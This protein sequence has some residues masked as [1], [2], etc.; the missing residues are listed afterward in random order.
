ME[1][2]ES[3]KLGPY[4]LLRR[5]ARGGMS[6]VYLV[7]DERNKQIYALKMVRQQDEEDCLRFQREIQVLMRL[8]HPHILPILDIGSQDDICYYVMPYIAQGTLKKRLEER[9]P[10]SEKEAETILTSIA[11]A[12]HFL[13]EA[14]FVHR[15]VKPSN[16]LQDSTDHVWLAD[17]GLVRAIEGESDLTRTGC[18]VGTPS[19]M[20]PEL[21]TE[22]ANVSSDI[23]ALGIVLYEMLTG[24]LPFT[25]KTAFTIYWKQIYEQPPPP[26]TL[27]TQ[28]SATVEQV[29]L[30]ALEKNPDDRYAS[31]QALAQAYQQALLVEHSTSALWCRLKNLRRS[32]RRPYQAQTIKGRKAGSRQRISLALGGLTVMALF[33]LGLVSVLQPGALPITGN[34]AHAN[35]AVESS[36]TGVSTSPAKITTPTPQSSSTP[37]VAPGNSNGDNKDNSKG[38]KGDNSK[39]QGNGKSQSNGKDKP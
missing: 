23:Y 12:L 8:K 38:N 32:R 2:L 29:I 5:L 39:S 36:P 26:S 1:H 21:D 18:L 10:L 20:A 19:Y 9:G 28:I 33:I 35:H 24:C 37:V 34:P 13:H 15:D 31:V 6:E 14:G 30:Q 17:F 4:L 27:N 22:Q 16:I 25:G 3:M 11:S 7:S